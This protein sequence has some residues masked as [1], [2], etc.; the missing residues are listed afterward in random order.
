MSPKKQMN[1][2]FGFA[3]NAVS[4]ADFLGQLVVDFEWRRTAEVLPAARLT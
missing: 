2:G 1:V 3:F 4:F